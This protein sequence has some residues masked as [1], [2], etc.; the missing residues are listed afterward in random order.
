[1][2]NYRDDL[3]RHRIE[4]ADETLEDARILA[5]AKRWKTCVNRLYYACFYAV[6]ALL[7][8]QGLS[9]SKTYRGTKPF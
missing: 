9:S 8:Q 2:S 6:S 4:R 1:M 7:I 3:M 5:N